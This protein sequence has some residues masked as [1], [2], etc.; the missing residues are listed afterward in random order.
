MDR[1]HHISHRASSLSA[2]SH[3]SLVLL[4]AFYLPSRPLTSDAA[5]TRLAQALKLPLSSLG[6]A[7]IKDKRAVTYQFVSLAGW[8]PSRPLPAIHDRGT[9]ACHLPALSA[10]PPAASANGCGCDGGWAGLQVG[11]LQ[12][13]DAP[14]LLGQLQGNR[15]RV[16]RQAGQACR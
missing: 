1:H 10:P 7:G 12:A 3:S 14:L 2:Q 8:P 4:S 5:L 11:Q 15:F 6:V 13:C 16:G 9:S